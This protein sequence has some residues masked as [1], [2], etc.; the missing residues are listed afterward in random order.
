M[1][2][3]L[4]IIAGLNGI[5]KTTSAFDIVPHDVPIVNSD[6]IAKELRTIHAASFNTQE[7]ANQE[8]QA[9]VQQHLAER[10][11]FA[12]ETNLSY[13]ETWRFL[14]GVKQS[15]Y[16]LHLVFL[17]ADDLQLLQNRIEERYQRGE[18]YVRPDIVAEVVYVGLKLLRHFFQ[19]PHTVQLMD[20]SISHTPIALKRES[21]LVLLTEAP[22]NWFKENLTIHFSPDEKAIAIKDLPNIDEAR[23]R[24]QQ[25][26]KS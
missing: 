21:Q 11:T 6:E 23:K 18:Q 24:Y 25:Q 7:Y 3:V 4:Y 2:P 17:T 15:G 22:P 12:I 1:A 13:E 5:G 10:K 20:N 9:L 14:I 19:V 16:Q 8:A 26:S